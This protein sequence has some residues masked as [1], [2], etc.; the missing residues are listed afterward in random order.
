LTPHLR[1][2]VWAAAAPKGDDRD[3]KLPEPGATPENF[4]H[5]K[6]YIPSIYGDVDNVNNTPEPE[7]SLGKVVEMAVFLLNTWGRRATLRDLATATGVNH[8]GKLRAKLEGLG[9]VFGMDAKGKHH[10]GVWLVDGWERGLD[11]RRQRGGEFRRGR[12]QAVKNREAREAFRGDVQADEEPALIGRERV[13]EMVE[14]RRQEER[15]RQAEEVAQEQREAERFIV[16]QLDGKPSIRFGLLLDMWTEE[17]REAARRATWTLRKALGRLGYSLKAH[18]ETPGEMFVYQGKRND[19]RNNVT[20]VKPE[21]RPAD[22]WRSHPLTCECLECA[23]AP[24]NYTKLYQ[25]SGA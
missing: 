1:W 25:G 21:E 20:E 10:A 7:T 16:G 15:G 22:D 14:K 19:L 3:S 4:L 6:P 17:H 9:D 24:P 12:R 11:G 18:A 2:P 23:A 8:T 5:E 13:E